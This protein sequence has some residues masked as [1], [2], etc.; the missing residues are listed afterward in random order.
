[1]ENQRPLGAICFRS[2][3]MQPTNPV[4][5]LTRL[6]S[7]EDVAAYVR[8]RRR[9]RG[10]T[11]AELALA[12]GVGRRLVQKLERG[13]GSVNLEGT[14]RIVTALSVDILARPRS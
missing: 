5:E 2:E 6:T 13:Q 14:L 4:P 8:H 11:Q 9:A 3:A 7:Q 12:A 1:M 10:L